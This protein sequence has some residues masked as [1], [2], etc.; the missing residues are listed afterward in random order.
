MKQTALAMLLAAGQVLAAPSEVPGGVWEG[1]LG[2]QPIVACFNTGFASGSYF[3]QR[4]KAPIQLRAPEKTPDWLET[5]D[6]GRWSLDA[7]QGNAL[8]GTWRSAK[9]TGA[10]LP[11]R[12]R[13]VDAGDSETACGG[14]AYAGRLE[15]PPRVVPG[16]RKDYAPGRSYRPLR[17]AGQE[18]LELFAPEPAT[19]RINRDLRAQ[20]DMGKEAL[21]EYFGKRRDFLG[22]MGFPAED[23]RTA[24]PSYW[25]SQWLSV[26]FYQWAAGTGRNGIS[27]SYTT[28]DMQSG[29]RVNPWS[30]VGVRAEGSSAALT[31]RLRRFLFRRDGID[32]AKAEADC[33]ANYAEGAY[34][35]LTL[36]AKG[37]RFSQP[38]YGR[39][40]ELDFEV[41]YAE[42]AP[43]LSP[44]GKAAVQR[45]L[46]QN[47]PR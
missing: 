30:W 1:T 39:G 27:W 18:T 24:E 11:I 38:E 34:Y 23:E 46:A 45:I 44:A 6:T 3:Y 28:W 36:E 22:R 35:D 2:T 26:R 42:L 40:C 20:L 9:G 37:L 4:H 15:T 5:G 31:P 33:E 17:F 8:T 16:T 14:D 29:Q 25:N 13:R 19:A 12:L 7:V 47:L 41:P 43:V 10:A 21:D 32:P